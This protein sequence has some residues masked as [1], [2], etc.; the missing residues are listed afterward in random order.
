MGFRRARIQKS[1]VLRRQVLPSN[2]GSSFVSEA[3]LA[4]TPLIQM[5]LFLASSQDQYPAHPDYIFY[6]RGETLA[7]IL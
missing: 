2:R 7:V 1:N 4:K 6:L 3:H 5:K